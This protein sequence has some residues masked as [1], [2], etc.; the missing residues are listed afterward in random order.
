MKDNLCEDMSFKGVGWDGCE[1]EAPYS[2]TLAVRC[3]QCADEH[4]EKL[5]NA[6]MRK[7][8]HLNENN[9]E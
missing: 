1:H 4:I 7:S 5:E 2:R 3:W 9:D 6:L 8:Q